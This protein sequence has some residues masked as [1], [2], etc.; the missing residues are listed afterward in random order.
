M[1]L[2]ERLEILRAEGM[3]I[4][5]DDLRHISLYA[6]EH[7]LPY[8]EYAFDFRRR[9]RTGALVKARRFRLS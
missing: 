1:H 8:G 4:D 6:Y 7:I 5:P 2:T 9:S 3:E